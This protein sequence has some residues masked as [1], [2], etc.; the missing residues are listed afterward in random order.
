METV[1]HSGWGR[2]A[3]ASPGRMLPKSPTN[4]SPYRG[5]F[6]RAGGKA[7]LLSRGNDGKLLFSKPREQWTIFPLKM[8]LILHTKGGKGWNE[9]RIPCHQ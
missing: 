9:G 3:A 2:R 6:P 4:T 5:P 8:P 7:C 1:P